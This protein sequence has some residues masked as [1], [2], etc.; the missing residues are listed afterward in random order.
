M[1]ADE[2]VDVNLIEQAILEH[3]TKLFPLHR[4]W[5][6]FLLETENLEQLDDVVRSIDRAGRSVD[7]QHRTWAG[8]LFEFLLHKFAAVEGRRGAVV[9][10]PPSVIGTLVE[11]IGLKPGDKV[12]DPCADSGGF[13]LGAAKY[14]HSQG[15]RSHDIQL[16]GRAISERSWALAQMNLDLHGV[17]ADFGRKPGIVLDE[18]PQ[19]AT[20]YDVILANPPFNMVTREAN[21]P[22][23]RWL[24]GR[25]PMSNANFA[26]LQHIWSSLADGGRAAVV[27]ANGASS[28]QR[29][30]EKKIRGAMAEAGIIEALIAL[31]PQLFSTTSIPVTA[32][33]LRKSGAKKG[34]DILLVN[35]S[36]SGTMISRTQRALLPDDIREI[37][38]A[39]LRWRNRGSRPAH[40]NIPGFSRAVP[41]AEIRNYD[42]QLTP[43]RY[44]GSEITPNSPIEPIIELRNQLNR[45]HTRA[46]S[47]DA[48]V[49]RQLNRILQWTP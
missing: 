37:S 4:A 24:F 26:W 42:Y 25:P 1:P 7:S 30:E 38:D 32:W 39:V 21:P 23:G 13:L 31:P 44:V 29:L 15:R 45:L 27:M 18:D 48:E 5:R 12:L 17:P 6:S 19:P 16:T 8:E 40:K 33:I 49:T 14:L 41:V 10:T 9:V 2:R 46:A 35:A 28:S 34:E 3:G 43:G 36:D 20:R 47:V 11:L 22:P